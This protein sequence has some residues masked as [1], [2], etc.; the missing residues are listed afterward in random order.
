MSSNTPHPYN[1]GLVLT[2][3]QII[4]AVMSLAT[5]AKIGAL[6]I[7]CWEAVPA[8]HTLEF[9]GHPQPPTP[10]QT[11]NTTVLGIINNNI[12]K[13]LKA[14]DM[15]TT[16]FGTESVRNNSDTAGHRAMKTKETTSPNIM[17]QFI[18][19]LCTQLFSPALP[20]C[21][22]SITGS[23]ISF[24]QQG[25]ARHIHRG[26]IKVP[27]V[28]TLCYTHLQVAWQTKGRDTAPPNCH[29]LQEK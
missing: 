18:I 29:A 20:P 23:Q 1:N 25:C 26:I 5:K 19:R 28:R 9:L 14:M 21:K 13:K 2:I 4:K 11:D 3:V 17:P 6:Y 22:H 24:L 27:T 8:C 10:I 16:G 7:N 12:M 15:S